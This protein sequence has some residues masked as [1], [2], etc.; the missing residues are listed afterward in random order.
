MLLIDDVYD[1]QVTWQHPLQQMDGPSLE[2]FGQDSVV[3]VGTGLLDNVPRP[4]PGHLFDVD[5]EPHELGDGQ[6]R[7]GVVQLDR[8]LQ[9]E[10]SFEIAR[11]RRTLQQKHGC[12]AH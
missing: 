7:V 2:R 9:G 10:R 5:K 4:V 12:L 1:F 3:C 6:G 11:I 8:D